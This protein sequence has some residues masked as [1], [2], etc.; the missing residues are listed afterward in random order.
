MDIHLCVDCTSRLMNM[1]SY[2]LLMSVC[3]ILSG[4]QLQRATTENVTGQI[5]Y[6]ANNEHTCQSSRV[7][8]HK[9]FAS[10]QDA[11][12]ALALEQYS[13]T[14]SDV[15]LAPGQH[16]F[17]SDANYTIDCRGQKT[18]RF[19][20]EKGRKEETVI[21]GTTSTK[22]YSFLLK[23]RLQLIS[24]INVSISD[25]T[26]DQSSPGTMFSFLKCQHVVVNR[27]T[28]INKL[29]LTTSLFFKN[30]WPVQI[31]DSTFNFTTPSL[32]RDS[33]QLK[34]IE[35]E[36]GNRPVYFTMS[37]VLTKE[38]D[39]LAFYVNNCSF[40]PLASA[41]ASILYGYVNLARSYNQ[42]FQKGGV[43][44][45]VF[46]GE[47]VQYMKAIISHCHFRQMVYGYGVPLSLFLNNKTAHNH[48]TLANTTFTGNECVAG[49]AILALFQDNP[50]NNTILLTDTDFISNTAVI[51]GGAVFALYE[52]VSSKELPRNELLFKRCNFVDNRATQ[53]FGAGSAVMI[54]SNKEPLVD[55]IR[56]DDTIEATATFADC[57]FMSN[58]AIYGTVFAKNSDI[59]YCGYW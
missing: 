43:M 30:T 55:N 21:N 12:S 46:S 4:L 56:R 8:C 20:S 29:G 13:S 25:L 27:C 44:K 24:C 48:I 6:V 51:E 9:C 59:Y 35:N 50:S 39:S 53:Y 3:A 33:R 17:Y 47:D 11:L 58:T 10:F 32:L 36:R 1:M 19:L 23:S 28:F 57:Q 7:D 34:L 22:G 41:P 40:Q 54:Y 42:P 14:A 18:I 38:S 45:V 26:V 52:D 16:T 15:I 2:S 49:C 37:H 31:L 5:L